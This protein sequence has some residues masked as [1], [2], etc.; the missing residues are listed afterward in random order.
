MWR[1]SLVLDD[2][3]TTVKIRL[4]TVG[5]DPEAYH[6]VTTDPSDETSLA[7]GLRPTRLRCGCAIK[8]DQTSIE[9]A[10][11]VRHAFSFEGLIVNILLVRSK[12]PKT[13]AMA[14]E[15]GKVRHDAHRIVGRHFSVQQGILGRHLI[16]IAL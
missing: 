6:Q 5:D 3:R 8:V 14:P 13:E 16:G 9:Q 15:V 1:A 12:S 7:Q 4:D 2:T 10:C 11:D